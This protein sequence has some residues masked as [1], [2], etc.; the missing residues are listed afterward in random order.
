MF[1][2]AGGYWLR[3]AGKAP[4]PLRSRGS[5]THRKPSINSAFVPLRSECNQIILPLLV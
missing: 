5:T 2:D 4:P 3:I 1:A